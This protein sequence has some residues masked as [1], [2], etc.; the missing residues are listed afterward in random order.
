MQ[1]KRVAIQGIRGAFHHMAAQEYFGAE[2]IDIVEC[3]TFHELCTIL[4]D[5]KADY[6]IMAVKNTIVGR[7]ESNN[8]LMES[9]RFKILDELR[10][11]IVMNLMALSGQKIGMLESIYSHSIALQQDRKSVV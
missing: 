10:L 11:R 4:S 9:Y 8:K 3:P 5:H 6:G 2:S 7:I 1:K